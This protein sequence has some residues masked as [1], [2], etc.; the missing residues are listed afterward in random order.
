MKP[1]LNVGDRVLVNKLS[2]DLHDVNR[3]D[4]VV[5]EAPPR[6]QSGG[7]E[8]LVK[9]VIGRPGE[10]VTFRDGQVQIDDR[11]L[12]EPYLEDGATTTPSGETV[13]PGCGAPAGGEPG[14]VVPPGTV[15]MMG[16]NREA[17][18]DS[19]RLRAHQAGHHRRARLRPH[20]AALGPRLPL[21]R[22][23]RRRPLG[24]RG[25]E[26]VDVVA[27]EGVDAGVEH[28]SDVP[29]LL[30]V[31]G[32]RPDVEAV[33]QL[34]EPARPLAVMQVDR[35]DPVLGQIRGVPLHGVA[36][37]VP[38]RRVH[39]P[40]LVGDRP[41]RPQA[42]REGCRARA[43]AEHPRHERPRARAR[44]RGRPSGRSRAR[45]RSRA[46]GR[47]RAGA[48]RRG[49]PDARWRS[50]RP[51]A[52]GAPPRPG[53][54]RPRGRGPAPPRRRPAVQASVSRPPTPA[55]RACRKAAR[56]SRA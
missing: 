6:A 13:P 1:T 33:E 37:P 40:D 34:D 32:E 15:F 56:C 14:C 30:G 47:A 46:S 28:R 2:Y 27:V 43:V 55:S 20:L 48:G 44:R 9:R 36:D 42:R 8:D 41:Q 7:I 49:R 23:A 16:D 29:H 3:G 50:W 24:D 11:P 21:I 54:R 53:A 10:T 5:F 22:V 25:D 52:G 35:V 31:P 26:T 12:N 19:T 45:S 4:I 51:G 18:K 38:A 17:S 39:E